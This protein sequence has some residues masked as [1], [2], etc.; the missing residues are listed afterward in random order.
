M[1]SRILVLDKDAELD[2]DS[3]FEE[4]RSYGNGVDYIT[5]SE[6]PFED[7]YSWFMGFAVDLGFNS[8]PK[9][10][11]FMIY[12][13]CFFWDKMEQDIRDILDERGIRGINRWE[14]EDR[15]GMKR[16]F[17]FYY[18]GQLL[19]FPYFMEY[20]AKGDEHRGFKIYKFLD[21]HY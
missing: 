1:H 21:Y 6:S 15:A 2:L 8:T 4:M 17:W 11:G 9:R 19:T 5:E 12:H 20:Y 3:M 16:G 7:D 14:I 18:D 13:D 10:D